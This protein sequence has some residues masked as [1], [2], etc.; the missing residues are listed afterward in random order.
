MRVS[1]GRWIS[2]D[3]LIVAG[4]AGAVNTG[5]V[6]SSSFDGGNGHLAIATWLLAAPAL[7]W[8]RAV[9]FWSA[10]LVLIGA[11]WRVLG[12]RPATRALGWGLSLGMIVYLIVSGVLLRGD[13]LTERLRLRLEHLFAATSETGVFGTLLWSRAAEVSAI[14][15]MH[16]VAVFPLAALLLR[17][18]E[19]IRWPLVRTKLICLSAV[20]LLVLAGLCSPGLSGRV[21]SRHS[22]AAFIAFRRGVALRDHGTATR[23]D[24]PMV[25]GEPESCLL[26]HADVRGL[27]EWHEPKTIGCAA[28]HLGDAFASD[29]SGA[30]RGMV[31]VPG[32]LADS[33]RTCGQAGC[34]DSVVP[35][36]E[37][38]IMTTMA[39]VVATDRRVFG[40]EPGASPDIR[41]LGT[42]AA[43]T[44][45]RQLC[46][47][48]H[49]AQEKTRWGA[50]TEATRGGGC[51]ACHLHYTVGAAAE[52]A[53]YLSETPASTARTV[54]RQHPS[55]SV[56]P[57]SG[58]CF[59]CHSRSG[60]IA[61]NFE[62]WIEAQRPVSSPARELAD[63]RGLAR[64]VPDVHSERGL[65]CIDC[66]TASEV[67][68][69]GVPSH[70][71]REQ[72]AIRC[73]DC[74]SE[75][76]AVVN[77]PLDA[78]TEK[79]LRLRGIVLPPSRQ[80]AATRAGDPLVNILVGPEDGAELIAKRTGTKHPLRAPASMCRRDAGHARLSCESCHAAWA[81]RCVSCH[82]KYNPAEQGFDHLRQAWV[83]GAWEETGAAA[84]ATPPTLGIRF[85]NDGRDPTPGV[86][87]A[88][89]PGM[90]L[91]LDRRRDSAAPPDVVFQRLY[92]RIAPHTTRP[93]GRSCASCHIDSVALGFGEGTLRFE[94]SGATGRWQFTPRH[95]NSTADGLAADAWTGFLQTRTGRVST[96]EDV[97]PFNREEQKRILSVGACL[98]CHDGKSVPMQKA[99]ADFAATVRQRS[100]RCV[101]ATWPDE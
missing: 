2:A 40:E 27:G 15:F 17:R 95:E 3:E 89:A 16:A 41:T 59:G 100:A 99:L 44:H 57:D 26:C 83:A 51:N 82:T 63:G 73:E 92:A 97:R 87:E 93:E 22:A 68:G 19:C 33:R 62:G 45:A 81:P 72:L 38:S 86:V 67:M 96:R 52:L 64:A 56:N 98:T 46:A 4:A 23:A 55:L 12:G 43:D 61:T 18:G 48:C 35:R 69:R 13:P 65:D 37:K 8:L 74:H 84:T 54:P 85:E 91:D 50:N 30:H 24:L 10:L 31:R 7:D 60:R 66:H 58:N 29:A 90:I 53:T 88:F 32:N 77:R 14:S 80:I 70:F 6:L 28:C 42:S 11:G 39:G 20:G 71:Q 47:S 36:V 5:F 94:I 1:P 49:L 34:H 79:L 76:V 78:E 25:R 75:R 9:H 101:I 21:D